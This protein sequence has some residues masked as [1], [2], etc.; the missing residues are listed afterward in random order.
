MLDSKQI[1]GGIRH[2]YGALVFLARAMG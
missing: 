2:L 1:C